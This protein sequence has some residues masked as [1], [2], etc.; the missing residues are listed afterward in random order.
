MLSIKRKMLNIGSD[1]FFIKCSPLEMKVKD[2][3]DMYLKTEILYHIGVGRLKPSLLWLSG[4]MD[5]SVYV[6]FNPQLM[7]LSLHE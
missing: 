5:R 6:V 7:S 3:L 4:C 1:F 2:V